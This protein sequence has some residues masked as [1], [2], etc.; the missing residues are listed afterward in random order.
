MM[1]ISVIIVI[2]I[3]TIIAMTALLEPQPSLEDCAKLHPVITLDF[4]TEIFLQSKVASLASSPNLK[5]LATVFMFL[6]DRMAQLYPQ[7]LNFSFS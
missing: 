7:A 4:Q 3:T 2:I 1:A 5:D 6:S